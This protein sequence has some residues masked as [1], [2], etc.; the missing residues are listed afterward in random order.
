MTRTC[1]QSEDIRYIAD[2]LKAVVWAKDNL[3]VASA[4]T[5]HELQATLAAAEACLRRVCA[6]MPSSTNII[7]FDPHGSDAASEV[8]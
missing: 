2:M 1:L 3:G 7:P 4:E 8:A 5:L 6:E